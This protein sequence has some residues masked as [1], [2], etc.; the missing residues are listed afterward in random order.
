MKA[1]SSTLKLSASILALAAGAGAF[2]GAAQALTITGDNAS[3]TIADPLEENL[4]VA[5]GAVI[6]PGSLIVT[7]TVAGDVTNNG[8]VNQISQVS[9]DA[10]G[11]LSAAAAAIVL[12]STVSGN[13]ANNGAILASVS[14]SLSKDIV[15]EH[16]DALS[17]ETAES[18][19]TSQARGLHFTDVEGTVSNAGSIDV[20][21]GASSVLSASTASA[22]PT[23]ADVTVGSYGE[24]AGAIGGTDKGFT[25]TADGTIAA[26]TAVTADGAASAHGSVSSANVNA[27]AVALATG[28][29][30]TGV[31]SNAGGIDAAASADVVVDLSSVSTDGRADGQADIDALAAA[32]GLA[33]QN[34]ASLTN[35]GSIVVAADM[36]VTANLTVDATGG[37]GALSLHHAQIAASAAGIWYENDT[38][39]GKLTNSGTVT[40]SGA[41]ASETTTAVSS[42]DGPAV[43][44]GTFYGLWSDVSGVYAEGTLTSLDNSGAVTATTTVTAADDVTVTGE[45]AAD[46]HVNFRNTG[47]AI[48]IDLERVNGTAANN[49][50][51]SAAANTTIANAFDVGASGGQANAGVFGQAE[52]YGT[53]VSVSQGLT[54]AFSNGDAGALTGA[55]TTLAS[56]NV[57]AAGEGAFLSIDQIWNSASGDGLYVGGDGAHSLKN[58]GTI[59]GT[60]SATQTIAAAATAT[61]GQAVLV[62]DGFDLSSY[63]SG[64][65]DWGTVT[66][67]EN[68]GTITA[69]AT[70]VVDQTLSSVG[71]EG[72]SVEAD[73][74][75]EVWSDGVVLFG[76]VIGDVANSST[77]TSTASLNFTQAVIS[78]TAA[79]PGYLAVAN[80]IS[81]HAIGVVAHF[82]LPPVE[83]D[84]DDDDEQTAQIAAPPVA[85]PAP[86]D[87]TNS[88]TITASAELNVDTSATGGTGSETEGAITYGLLRAHGAE[89]T[90]AHGVITNS[91]EIS[92]AGKVTL[93]GSGD[94]DITA[95]VVGLM[96]PD[97]QA[98]G[99]VVN[100]GTITATLD[101]EGAD[102]SAV[103]ALLLGPIDD[104]EIPEGE[105]V[106]TAIETPETSLPTDTQVYTTAAADV[107]TVTNTGT[108]SATNAQGLSFGIGA[109]YAD[110]PVVI[111]Q[112][113]GS[114]SADVAIAMAQGNADTL[115]WTGGEI[116]GAVEADDLD[117]VNVFAGEGTPASKTIAAGE[118]FVLLGGASLNIGVKDAP[119]T[120]ALDGGVVGTG[121]VNV[122][123]DATLVLGPVAGIITDSFN[124]APEAALSFEF[125]PGEAGFIGVTGDANIDGTLTAVALPGLYGDKGGHKVLESLTKVNG[126]F[127]N[128]SIIG[129]TL[130]LDFSA[131]LGERDLTITWE[132]TPFDEVKGLTFNAAS[133][134]GA[135]EEGYDPARPT[136][137][138][139]PELNDILSALFTVTDPVKY[140]RV[141]NSWSGS[142]HAQVMRA[143]ANLSEPYL[144]ALSEHLNDIRRTGGSDGQTVMLRPKGSSNSIAPAS[145]AGASGS[146]SGFSFWGR[147]F[148]RW[149]DTRGDVNADGYDEDTYGAVL[150]ADF[151]VSPNVVI[152]LAGSYI[153]DSIDFDDGDKA[154]IE[155]WSIGGYISATF[156]RFYIDGSITYA[157]DNYKMRRTILFGDTGCLGFNCTSTA[158]SKYDGDGWL[159]HAE[160]G[161]SFDLGDATLQPFAGL[162]YSTVNLDPFSEVGGGDLGL[163]VLEGKGRSLQSRL[164]ARLSGVWGSGETKWIPE[165]RVEWRHEFKDD[166]AWIAANLTGLP[167]NPFV[168]IGSDVTGDLAVVGAGVT[169]LVSDSVGL[170]F[171]YQGAFG[172]GYN[173]HII[174]GGVRVRF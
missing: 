71:T 19:T 164:G 61:D 145:A 38:I 37:E 105:I 49:A 117:V 115:N 135:L 75:V 20:E 170:Y 46:S 12:D 56:L 174:Q 79:N 91:G 94:K 4:I 98:G 16:D 169:A 114:I 60:A 29:A 155:R 35:T 83:D 30:V 47:E 11:S 90:G 152:G 144:M 89:I 143:A 151:A 50:A 52:A 165:L 139:D 113:G 154:K 43:L 103:V 141:L 74:F 24:S 159:G 22:F 147:A 162:N 27:D 102:R 138:N 130:L 63:A 64:I 40:A 45:T 78:G 163:D 53:G 44:D 167:N 97:I 104:A 87:F 173:S 34:A 127:D 67:F 18:F 122:N 68:G 128:V 55:G 93:A 32:S 121:V 148:G 14:R 99:Q 150:G 133:V 17:G 54:G 171:D 72:S 95:E 77:I 149:A 28:A 13:V 132:R 116:H 142:E 81:V 96:L 106:A 112:Q 59:S 140:D 86:A 156:D 58:T 110:A 73:S 85:T 33:G 82:E 111:N 92:A 129:D 84:E 70:G 39:N 62:V 51:V 15:V 76:D 65:W 66:G 88:G 161:Y 3:V 1:F 118:D 125:L 6:T 166:P 146:E 160:V 120:F 36:S 23:E 137:K 48:G 100:S 134:A 21:S 158:S 124:M 107:I 109:V 168:A 31:L 57:T 153:D 131:V 9:Q 101:G 126:A 136:S 108:I 2:S 80:D 26:S 7:S 10:A 123:D 157:G 25:N 69:V 172:S 41:V 119:V 42:S 5:S 8:T